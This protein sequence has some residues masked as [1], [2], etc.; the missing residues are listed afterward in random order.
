MWF[1]ICFQTFAYSDMDVRYTETSD[2]N[3]GYDNEISKHSFI[4][5]LLQP[6]VSDKLIA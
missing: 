3:I 1:D 2:K 4:P 6:L 5:L